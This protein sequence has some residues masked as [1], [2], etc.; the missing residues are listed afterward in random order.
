MSIGSKLLQRVMYGSMVLLH[1]RSV[2]LQGGMGTVCDGTRWPCP[3]LSL[4]DDWP[5]PLL[6]VAAKELP[7]WQNCPV[8]VPI[9]GKDGPA[10]HH[11]QGRSDP[12]GM[13]IGKM[14]LP[15]PESRGAS[16]A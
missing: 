12:D 1:L 13:G 7:S 16:V 9:L 15:L 14:A 10:P 4:G 3:S 6:A 2:L 8:P 11:G 5:C